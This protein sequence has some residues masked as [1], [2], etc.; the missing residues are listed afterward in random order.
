M[1]TNCA[2]GCDKWYI[3]NMRYIKKLTLTK[4]VEIIE[5]QLK[6]GQPSCSVSSHTGL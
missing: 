4:R 1:D 5:K 2:V 3:I 6:K